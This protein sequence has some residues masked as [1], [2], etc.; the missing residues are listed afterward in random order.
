MR[1]S[2]ASEKLSSVERE[3]R[4]YFLVDLLLFASAPP[5]AQFLSFYIGEIEVVVRVL[6]CPEREQP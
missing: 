5:L 2:L 6:G 1:K 4:G 3:R